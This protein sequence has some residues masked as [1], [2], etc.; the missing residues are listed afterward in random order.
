MTRI[1]I[2][3]DE[4]TICKLYAEELRNEGY[5]VITTNVGKGLLEMIKE[6][7]PELVVLDV[8]MGIYDGLNLLQD[9]RMAHYNLPVILCS[10]YSSFRYDPKAIAADYYV[11][12]SV[13]LSELKNK[14]HMALD[15]ASSTTTGHCKADGNPAQYLPCI[16]E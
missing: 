15:T 9:V 7:R 14:I 16:A 6:H 12:K 11:V 5:D 3:D 8:R 1:L 10:A 13:D 4:D 2:V